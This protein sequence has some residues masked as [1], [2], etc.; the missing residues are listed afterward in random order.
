MASSQPDLALKYGVLRGGRFVPP[1]QLSTATRAALNE[2]TVEGLEELTKFNKKREEA[3]AA[4]DLAA[5]DKASDEGSAGAAAKLAET[6]NL[7]SPFS[8]EELAADFAKRGEMDGLDLAALREA[9]VVDLLNNDEQRKIVE[10]RLAPLSLTDYIMRGF[11]TQKVPIVPGEYEPEFISYDGNSDIELKRL[12]FEEQHK[13]NRPSLE[14][15]NRYYI[16]KYAMMA[17]CLSLKSINNKD[18]GT[19]KNS[20]GDFDEQLFWKKYRQF[21]RLPFHLI[22]SLGVHYSWFDHRVRRL[23]RAT[24]IKNG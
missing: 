3:A 8:P 4:A 22:A 21:M 12:I 18:Y 9:I 15:V 1:Q 14:G 2:K 16:D 10:A 7:S 11:V 6:G 17:I 23:V 5:A 13:A 24:A 19:V 20:D